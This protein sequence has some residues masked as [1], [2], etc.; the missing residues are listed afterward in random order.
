MAS[1][2]VIIGSPRKGNSEAI[3]LAIA[4]GAKS[5]GNSI[6]EFYLN[7]LKNGKGCQSCYGC[8]K[9]GRCVV[10]DDNLTILDAIRDADSIILSTPTY[11]GQSSGQFRLLEDRFFGFLNGDFSPNIAAGKKVAI[12]ETC[13]GGLDGAKKNADALEA[14]W[15][16]FFKADVV[17]KIVVGNMM[18][19]DAATK[20]KALMKEA[21]DLGKK[22]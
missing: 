14:E 13:G 2:V 6:Q 20:D 5:K 21:D 4:K 3:A 16:N 1:T 17:G 18:A 11:F 19:P 22:L 12:V 7:R 8:K 10:K 15:K 9:A